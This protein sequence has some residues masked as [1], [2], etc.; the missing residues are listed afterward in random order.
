MTIEHDES[1]P[2]SLAADL[3]LLTHA[4]FALFSVFGG[5][6]L[7][8]DPR[9]AFVHLPTV[10][11]S[12]W[13]NLANRTCPLTPLEKRLRIEAGQKPFEGGWIQHYLDPLV[14][15]FGMPRRAELVAGWSVLVWNALVYGWVLAHAGT[16]V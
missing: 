5:L 7:L 16:N 15:P 14:R 4:L 12:S 2:G 3:V 9:I 10:L 6:L 11:W 1:T 8:I 13:V